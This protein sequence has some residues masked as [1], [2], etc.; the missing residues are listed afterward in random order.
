MIEQVQVIRQK[1]KSTQDRQKSYADLRR[2][3]IEFNVGD[4]VLR[5][6]SPMKR[7]MRFGKR[8][9]LSQK[10]VGPYEILDRVEKGAYRPALPPTLARVHNVFHVSQLRKYV[11]DPSHLLEIENIELDDQLTYEEVPK[12]ILDAKVRKTR[13]GSKG[14][15]FVAT[16]AA[17]L[18]QL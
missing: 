9:K 8:E 6:V 16:V 4:K 18:G 1:M 17:V 7:F 5:K 3:E 11:S 10:Y 12:K 2:S 14:L 13:N 15:L